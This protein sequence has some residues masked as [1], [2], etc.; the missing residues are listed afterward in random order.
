MAKIIEIFFKTEV[1]MKIIKI[2]KTF[3]IEH[4]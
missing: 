4:K 1:S 3:V 2:T